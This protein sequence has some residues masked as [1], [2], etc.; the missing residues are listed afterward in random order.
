MLVTRSRATLG[1]QASDLLRTL[2]RDRTCGQA[3]RTPPLLALPPAPHPA[4]ASSSIVPAPPPL[5]ALL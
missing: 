1:P 3:G 4:P 2:H 5:A